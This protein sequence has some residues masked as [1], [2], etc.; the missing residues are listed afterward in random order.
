MRRLARTAL[1]SAAG[2]AILAG[3]D[4]PA[5]A[6]QDPILIA[7]HGTHSVYL[8]TGEEYVTENP[9]SYW[10]F[11][12]LDGMCGFEGSALTLANMD[13]VFFIQTKTRGAQAGSFTGTGKILNETFTLQQ[14]GSD[15]TVLR[16]FTGTGTELA[17]MRGSGDAGQ[18]A[19]ISVN[20]RVVFRGVAED[21]TKITFTIK[22]RMRAE[23]DRF[24][25]AVDGCRLS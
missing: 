10:D 24:D 18:Q 13:E 7:Q 20:L 2:L 4:G 22:A 17:Q 19:D 8:A 21:G 15:G 12:P 1:A 6:A 11:V 23:H 25:A 5:Y 16:T 3:I 9:Q 14:L